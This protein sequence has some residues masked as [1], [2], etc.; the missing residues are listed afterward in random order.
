VIN[1][2]TNTK[3]TSINVGQHPYGISR[4]GDGSLVYAVNNDSNNVSVI[5][6]A[7]NT[8]SATVPVDP[9]PFSLGNF[10]NAGGGCSGAPVKFTITV[11]PE[12]PSGITATGVLSP[13]T[14]VYG[15][16]S[17]STAFSLSGAGLKAGILVTAPTGFE[18][19]TNDITFTS[20]V[21]MGTGGTIPATQVYVRLAATTHVIAIR[22][23]FF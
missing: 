10:I 21:T 22:G 23:I 18:I 19:S 7:T 15:T 14:T 4:N 13:L 3:I 17:T 2:A 11:D 9:N 12:A 16:P 5:N 20:T 1:A 8:V 6:T